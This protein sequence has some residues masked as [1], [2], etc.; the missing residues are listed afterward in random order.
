MDSTDE[1][2]SIPRIM[3]AGVSSSVGKTTLVIALARAFYRRGLKVA[4]FKCGPDYIDPTYHARATGRPSHNLDGWMMGRDAV[5][6]TFKETTIGVDL[7]IIEGVMG[8]FDG[9][10]PKTEAGSSAE[11]AKWLEA[12]VILAIDAS[13]M[14]RTVAAIAKGFREYD[15]DVNVAGIICNRI[16]SKGH[17]DLLEQAEPH[18]PVLGGLPKKLPHLLPSRHLGLHVADEDSVAAELF[19]GL[20]DFAEEWLDLDAI[21]ELAQQAPPLQGV[22]AESTKQSVESCRIGIA[23]DDAFSFYYPDNLD[24]LQQLG[25]KLVYFS[26]MTDSEIP[27]VDGLYLGGGYPELH[28]ATLSANQQMRKSISRFAKAGGPIYA[29]CGG[30]M[31]LT[32]SIVD[33]SDEEFS[34]VGLLPGQCRMDSKVRAIGYVEAETSCASILGGKGL[35]FRGHQFRYSEITPAPEVETCAYTIR[36]RRSRQ[37]TP[38]GYQSGNVLASYVHAH[39]ASNPTVAAGLVNSCIEFGK[40]SNSRKGA[41]H[42]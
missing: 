26:P 24:R 19:D 41:S 4:C 34:M 29:E 8:L 27:E 38:A 1:N 16:G 25:A 10:G 9:A 11:I 30:M 23:R 36:T 20:A 22:T 37:A 42:G 7:T 21:L 15:P 31:Y 40:S 32:E 2:R 5:E 17:L 35:R 14:A 6:G 28:A 39:W 18:L 13:G 12:P 33:S 3:I